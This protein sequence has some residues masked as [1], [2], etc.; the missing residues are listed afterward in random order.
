MV[1]DALLDVDAIPNGPK[2]L[3]V[4]ELLVSCIDKTNKHS[5]LDARNH[6]G[7]DPHMTGTY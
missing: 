5:P 2:Q 4:A 7:M 3:G 1:L 6:G